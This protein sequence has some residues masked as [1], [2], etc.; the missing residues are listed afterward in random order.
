[1]SNLAYAAQACEPCAPKTLSRLEALEQR[2]EKLHALFSEA[3]NRVG[4]LADR[5]IGLPPPTPT[6]PSIEAAMPRP[7][8]SVRR[9]ELRI[10]EAERLGQRL[11]DQIDRLSVL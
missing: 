3:R 5:L 7:D 1:M 6:A 8:A 10:D 9:L 2:I 11:H 4:N